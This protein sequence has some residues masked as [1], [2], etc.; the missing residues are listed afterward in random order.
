MNYNNLTQLELLQTEEISSTCEKVF[1]VDDVFAILEDA[2]KNVVGGLHFTSKDD[3]INTTDLWRVIYLDEN[4]VGVVIYKAKHGLK[5]VALGI[6]NISKTA[7]ISVKTMLVH[8]FKL[9]FRNSWME[10]SEGVEAFITQNGGERFLIK[11]SLASKL[12][13]KNIVSLNK[14]GHHY[15]REILGVVKT[16]VMIG[17]VKFKEF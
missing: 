4:I 1:I 2:Y 16:K 3:L 12:T 11:N 14:N 15:N 10:V 5:M 9:T 13:G 8:L 6:A 7:R 17:T